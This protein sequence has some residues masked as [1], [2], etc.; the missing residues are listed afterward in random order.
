MVKTAGPLIVFV[1]STFSDLSEERGAVLDA[2]GRLKL[3]H[4][5]MEFFGARA[6]QPIKT[7]L[8]EVRQSDVLVVIV[9]HRYGTIVPDLG[10]SY[11]EAEYSEG[12]KLN[13]PCLVYVRDD[14]IPILPKYMERDPE[15]LKLLEKWKTK[16]HSRHTVAMFQNESRLAVQVAADLSRTMQDLKEGAKAR[17]AAKATARSEAS[18]GI[19]AE[20]TELVSEVLQQ[21]VTETS[22]ISA[23][24]NSLS[25]LLTAAGRREAKVFLSYAHADSSIVRQVANRLT[26]AGIRIWWDADNLKPGNV[27]MQEIEWQLSA[28]DF[29]VFFI[30][31][32]SVKG[33]WTQQEVQIALHQQLS[34]EGGAVM[35]PV[36]LEDA[37][38]PPLL[39]QVQWVDLR[40]R[41]IEKAVKQIVDAIDHWPASRPK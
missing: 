32:S 1:C 2:I 38:V 30:S 26:E 28:A 7:C 9:G 13:K 3:Q 24:R 10:I 4:D 5:S 41:K 35:L 18:D 34:G 15:K 37:E 21:G 20:I 27:W 40:D 33:G 14:N 17:A 22:L 29:I 11:P 6:Q 16:L 23:I 8:E 31:S 25:S 39:R 19:V 36:L 12:F